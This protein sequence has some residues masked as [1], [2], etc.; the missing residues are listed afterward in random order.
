[1]SRGS[2]VALIVAAIVVAGVAFLLLNPGDNDT[3]ESPTQDEATQTTPEPPAETTE[4]TTTETTEE[5]SADD[6][7]PV[8]ITV[9][10]GE[11]VGGI[12]KFSIKRGRPVDIR[13]ESDVAEEVHLHG[14]DLTEDVSP[15]T[16]ARFRFP[17]ELEGIFEL[18]L[19]ES[20]VQIATLEVR[21]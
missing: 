7:G 21:P 16:P 18:E 11:P 5:P 19:E 15:D 13:V 17:A 14:Y 3:A 9:R 2:R 6:V 20:Q 12:A 4:S 10:N 1:M 8:A